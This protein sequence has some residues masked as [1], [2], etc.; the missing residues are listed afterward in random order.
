MGHPE[1]LS[2]HTGNLASGANIH[3]PGK[4]GVRFM[5]YRSFFPF[6]SLLRNFLLWEFLFCRLLLCRR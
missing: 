6:H 2:K 1:Q 4:G 5:S 3:A